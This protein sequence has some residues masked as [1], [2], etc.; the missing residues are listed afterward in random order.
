MRGS[1]ESWDFQVWS[2]LR[3][4]YRIDPH[5]IEGLKHVFHGNLEV[6]R[7]GSVRVANGGE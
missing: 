1:S 6:G 7:K 3:D 5:K 4:V 2:K